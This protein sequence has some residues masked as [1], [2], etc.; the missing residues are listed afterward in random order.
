[1]HGG[2]FA[3]K[4]LLAQPLSDSKRRTRSWLDDPDQ[5][6][7]LILV[8]VVVDERAVWRGHVAGGHMRAAF[9][10]AQNRPRLLRLLEAFALA[11]RP[12]TGFLRDIIVERNSEH[13][14]TLDV[15]KRGLLPIVDLA[16]SAAMAAG[17]AAASTPARTGMPQRP[18]ARSPRRTSLCY[19]TPSS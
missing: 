11:D 2:A 12:P 3:T 18:P 9:P 8:Y 19:A 1:M 5:E 7:A 10:E 14:G 17:V 15:K 16:R 4:G 13:P 6:K